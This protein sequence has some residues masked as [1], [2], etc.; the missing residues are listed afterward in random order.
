MLAT[1]RFNKTDPDVN[2]GGAN[3]RHVVQA[4]EASLRRLQTDRIDVLFLHRYDA[5]TPIDEMMR[6]LEDLVR[7]CRVIHPAVG[8]WSAWQTQRARRHPGA[9]QLGAATGHP[10]RVQSG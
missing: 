3:R 9:Q 5:V 10:A 2:A 8:G 6:G 1:K 7:S 4:V